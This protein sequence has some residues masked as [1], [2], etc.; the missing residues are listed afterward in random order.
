MATT[1]PQNPNKRKGGRPLGSLNQRPPKYQAVASNSTSSFNPF[2]NELQESQTSSTPLTSPGRKQVR[3]HIKSFT[4]DPDRQ[5][6]VPPEFDPFLNSVPGAQCGVPLGTILT[7]NNATQSIYKSPYSMPSAEAE[8][9]NPCKKRI[10]VETLS[11]SIEPHVTRPL[12]PQ[13]KRLRLTEYTRV[14]EAM[15]TALGFLADEFELRRTASDTFPPNITTS[16]IRSSITQYETEMSVAS[17]RSVCCSCGEFVP[18]SDIYEID[19]GHPFIKGLRDTLDN[20]GRRG[21]TWQLCVPCHTALSR[22]NIP[23]FS[24]QNLINVTTCQTYPSALEGL[25]PV[26]ECLIAKCHPIG[27][28]LKLRPGNHQSPVNYNALRGHMILIPQDPGPLL[29]ILPSPELRLDNLIRVF[30]LGKRA[31][32]D[33]DL[34]PFLQV[35]K[36]KV[37][38]ALQYLIRH[39]HLYHELTLNVPMIDTWTDEFIPTEIR[40]NIVCLDSPDGHER[41]GYTVSLQEGNYEND[42]QA[43][44]AECFDGDEQGPLLTTS[45]CT[46]INGERQ[47]PN[48]KV[49]DS[50][51]SAV[52]SEPRPS[53]WQSRVP[54]ISYAIRG[55]APLASNWENPAFFTA[56][57]PT[58]F[59]TGVGGHLDQRTLKVS[60]IAFANWALNH[61]S[62]RFARHKTFMYLLYDVS[63]LRSSSLGNTLLIKRQNWRSTVDD[64]RSLTVNQLQDAATKLAGG[65]VIIDD[66]V[67]RRLQR[68][69]VTIGMHVPGSFS[70]KLKLRSQIRGLIVREGMPAYWVTINPSDL[71]NALVLNLAGIEYPEDCI[72]TAAAAIRTAAATS[73]PVAVAQFFHHTCKAFFNGLLASNT[74]HPGI[75]GDVANHFGVVETNGRGMLHLHALVWLR[76][77]LSFSTLR[78]RL[79]QDKAYAARMIQYLETIIVQSIH[80]SS[81]DQTLPNPPD[82]PLCSSS[83]ESDDEFRGKLFADSNAV[84]CKKQLHSAKHNAT[85]FKYRQIE[86]SKS[87][88]R[89]GMPRDIVSES[90]VDDKLG[91]IHLAR[92]H[93]WV[94]PWNPA[95]AT[96]MRSNHDISW[97]PT[98]AKSLCL[99]YYITNYATKD[100]ISPW[101]IV[102]KAALLRQSIEKA[103][104]TLTPDSTD[105]RLRRKDMDQ[106]A[107]RCFNSLSHDREVRGVQ[108]ASTLLQLPAYYTANYNFVSVNLWWL[109][110]YVRLAIMSTD[111]ASMDCSELMGDEQCAYQTGDKGPVSLFDNYRC[112]GP[113]LSHIPFFNYCMLVQAKPER[114]AVGTDIDYD[115]HHPKSGLYVQRLVTKRSQVAT[116]TFNGQF[117]EFQ[118]EE[119]SVQGGHPRTTAMDNDLAEILLGLFVPWD[120]LCPLFQKQS[121]NNDTKKDLYSPIWKIIEPMLPPHNRTFARNIELLRKSKEDSQVDA[122]LRSREAPHDVFDSELEGIDPADLGSEDED[123]QDY[124]EEGHSTETLV[125]AYY[126]IAKSWC[127]QSS[128]TAQRISTL[129]VSWPS[130]AP[131]LRPANLIP[132]DIFQLPSYKTSCLKYLPS[133]T[134]QHWEIRIKGLVRLDETD[135]L[136][137]EERLAYGIDDFD[138]DITDGMLHPTLGVAEQPPDLTDQRSEVGDHPTGHSLT[139]LVKKHVPLNEKQEVIIE[140]VLSTALAWGKHPYDASKRDQM[141][142]Y[143]GGEGGVGKSQIIKGLVAGMDLIRRKREIILM[144]PTGAAADNICGNTYHTS[145][146]ISITRT[147]KPSVPL[148]IRKLWSQKTIMIIDEISMMDLSMI[149]TINSQCKIARC[150]AKSSPDLF[151]DLPVVIFM[152]DFYQFSLVKGQPLWKCPRLGRDNEANGQLIWHRFTDVIILDQQMRQADDPA[153]RELLSRARAAAL[154]ED[155][156]SFL[157]SKIPTSLFIPGL[158]GITTI[159]KLNALRHHMSFSFSDLEPAI[160]PVFPFEKSITLKNYS[161]R[162]KQVPM[163]PAFS[164]TDYK[165]QGSTLPAAILDL[166]N[167]GTRRQTNDKNYCSLYVQLSRLQSSAG[168]YLLQKLDMDDLRFRPDN[169]LLAEMDR[170]MALEEQTLSSWAQNPIE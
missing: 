24:A 79:L 113:L 117:S 92:N 74:T 21:D 110:R 14:Q 128:I 90:T 146:G 109:R 30:W 22:G 125:S 31:P 76:G 45:V 158:E 53:R 4:S 51:L 167:S 77:N 169:G 69:I 80:P 12:L 8:T 61:H 6:V 131:I 147:Q 60:L 39:N 57:F 150:V 2:Y 38:A 103:K 100:D 36:D 29:Q 34:R 19:N 145:L 138:P 124:I 140:R 130:Q 28:I 20:C 105:L 134:L 160:I 108:I 13:P 16:C 52:A 47:N 37:L 104:T 66:P 67:I 99:I 120:Q 25:T 86:T 121:I 133:S 163:C 116:V 27:T 42:L 139:A 111:P 159:V 87:S 129:S 136:T 114:D 71:R 56:A 168:L 85:C 9:L 94:N 33:A 102:L 93:G 43:T 10:R 162:W 97:I 75:L 141:L 49:V 91:V 73:N 3:R 59:P 58:L 54:V 154:T 62:R 151:G 68:S 41:E 112:R 122:A 166:K 46:D 118:A 89:F 98:V 83:L 132:L 70:Q 149:T 35:R 26:E 81:L 32:G 165:V 119:E 148:R 137:T 15:N 101:Q 123:V 156:L 88:C 106:F 126:S 144:A 5:M 23:K 96:C 157:N 115:A 1:T 164:L 72:P 40:D 170:L 84:A 95:I 63:Q 55:Q 142:L 18:T 82:T 152:G 7:P 44:Q 65:D 127:I 143:I 64:I 17:R 78:E 48:I 135:D 107:L 11:V 155:D 50:L 153:F 161:V